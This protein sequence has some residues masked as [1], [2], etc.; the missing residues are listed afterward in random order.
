MILGDNFFHGHG[1]SQEVH[2]PAQSVLG[3][4]LFLYSVDIPSRYGIVTLN[5]RD[6]II[7]IIEKPVNSKS[8]LAITGL[9]Y[10]DGSVAGRAKKLKKSVRGELEITDLINTYLA[11]KKVNF[12]MLGRGY[13]WFDVGIPRSLLDASNY[14]EVIQSRQG[15]YIAS[16]EEVALRM[17]FIDQILLQNIVD[18]IPSGNYREYLESLLI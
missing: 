15:I 12:S 8:K 16:P 11:E 1:L 5:D 3:A 2:A 14:V 18:K 17:N 9:Y 7:E 4:H 10:F 13:V 6:E